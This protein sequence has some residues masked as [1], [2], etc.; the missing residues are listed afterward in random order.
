LGL[1]NVDYVFNAAHDLGEEIEFKRGGI[2]QT[3]AQK[4]LAGAH[5]LLERI[6]QT[7]LLEAIAD[8]TFGDVSR[9]EDE[10]RGMEGI[11]ETD[12]DYFNPLTDLMRESTYA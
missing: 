4:V 10:G 3:H 12:E 5:E 6:A 9:K 8:A 11:V 2:V 7:G 1:Q